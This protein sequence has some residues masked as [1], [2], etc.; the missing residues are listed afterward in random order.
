[1]AA[2]TYYAFMPHEQLANRAMFVT[3]L[4]I[5]ASLLFLHLILRTNTLA[6]IHRQ[7]TSLN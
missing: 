2:R 1:M 3:F 6:V 7:K 4:V 5:T